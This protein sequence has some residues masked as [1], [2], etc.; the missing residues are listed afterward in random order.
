MARRCNKD[1]T[2]NTLGGTGSAIGS[3]FGALVLRVISL[4]FRI[5]DVGSR[6]FL[7]RVR[8]RRIV[9]LAFAPRGLAPGLSGV[10]LAGYATKANGGC[11]S[12]GGDRRNCRRRHEHPGRPR[13]LSRH[14]VR[15]LDSVL[16]IMQMCEAKSTDHLR[17]HRHCH[18]SRAW[19]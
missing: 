11:L 17:Q 5:F 14:A 12:A 3:I 15:C 4:N 13:P 6:S 10:M 7:A 19:P 8:T 9:V 18:A 1:V 16:S 2:V